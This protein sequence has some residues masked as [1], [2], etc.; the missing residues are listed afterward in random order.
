M[1]YSQI[2]KGTFLVATQDIDGIIFFRSVL[3]ICE[4]NENG[5][6]GLV[7]NKSIEL[8]LPEEVLNMKN[9]ENPQVR[10]LSGGPIQT[11]QM[12]LLHTSD[13]ISKQTLKI[14]DDVYLG[15]DLTFLQE[16]LTDNQDLKLIYVL[17]IQDGAQPSLKENFLMATGLYTLPQSISFSILQSTSSGRPS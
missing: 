3:L 10:I 13:A 7:I 4:H 17:V 8:E 14:C 6:F 5:S 9:L 16:A 12:M 15:G 1:P 11:N 2:Q